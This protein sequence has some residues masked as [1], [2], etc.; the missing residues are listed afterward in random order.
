V[1]IS[2]YTGHVGSGKTYEVIKNVILPALEKGRTVVCNIDGI[3]P[4]AL[5]AH[6]DALGVDAPGELVVVSRDDVARPDFFPSRQKDG[7]YVASA[8]VPLGALVV[9]DE[10]HHLWGSG[11]GPISPPHMTFFSEHRHIVGSDGVACDLVLITQAIG[12]MHMKLRRLVQYDVDCRQ[13]RALGL[14][15]KYSVC[16]YDG[17]RQKKEF[18]LSRA[19]KTYDPKIFRLYSSFA[20]GNGKVLLTDK[21]FVIWNNKLFWLISAVALV[22]LVGSVLRLYRQFLAPQQ[23]LAAAASP[24]SSVS[25]PPL[26]SSKS[27][28]ST[29]LTVPT[30][31]GGESKGPVSVWHIAGRVI[32]GGVD[33]VVLHRAGFPLRYL[34]AHLC[35][36]AFGRPVTCRVGAEVFEPDTEASS[37]PSSASGS[38]W[39]VDKLASKSAKVH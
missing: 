26:A 20:A 21:R 5:E 23:A 35:L 12:Q 33:Y 13:L 14:S 15:K 17:F 2:L 7:D 36:L 11:G 29:V 39:I 1:T 4:D 25:V 28:V 31:I 3:D 10:A 16:V 37:S 27:T 19:T 24:S 18:V 38:G 9:V 30:D 34:P 32:F 8:F 6:F 22:V